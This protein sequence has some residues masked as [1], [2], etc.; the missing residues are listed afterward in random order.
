MTPKISVI[1]PVFKVERFISKCVD[2]LLKQTLDDVE[3]IFVDDCSPDR[4]IQIIREIRD[5]YP[6]RMDSVSILRHSENHGLP[7]ARNT[8]LAHA[9]GEYIFH[10][11]GD[12]FVEPD[13]LKDMYDEAKRTDADILWCDWYLSFE[14]NERYMRQPEYKTP[15]NALRGILDGTM[16]FNVWNKLV[17]KS[18]YDNNNIRFPDGYS[19]GEDM[20]MIRLFACASRVSYIP[21]AYYHYVR[22]NTGSFTQNFSEKRLAEVMH[23]TSE[24]VDFVQKRKGAKWNKSCEHFKLNVKLPFLISEKKS[25]YL[26]WQQLYPESNEYIWGNKVLP[27]RTRMLQLAACRGQ[28]WLVWLYNIIVMRLMYGILYK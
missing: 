20:T 19:M 18:L 6:E 3:F 12:D 7:S 23:N 16:K 24:T 2:S 26:I 8:G 27:F 28:W 15:D 14:H 4:S 9:T 22:I 13:M 11:D 1:I 10:C 21:N 17:R 5:K 25:S